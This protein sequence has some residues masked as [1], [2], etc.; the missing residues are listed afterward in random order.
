[1]VRIRRDTDDSGRYAVRTPRRADAT[2]RGH[3]EAPREAGP[4]GG[5]PPFPPE[6]RSRAR[7]PPGH[8]ADL[9]RIGCTRAERRVGD[10]Q[11]SARRDDASHV[12]P[13]I[14]HDPRRLEGL[15]AERRGPRRGVDEGPTAAARIAPGPPLER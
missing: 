9:R 7:G 12:G 6:R 14:A 4:P 5:V 15:R 13:A 8:R 10:A 2:P 1:M 11:E 3:D